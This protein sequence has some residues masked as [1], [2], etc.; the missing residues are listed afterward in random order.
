MTVAKTISTNGGFI[1]WS[2]TYAEIVQALE[3]EK[4]PKNMVCGVCYQGTAG[5][6]AVLVKRH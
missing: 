2:G 5:S 3:D 4:V 6:C 1:I